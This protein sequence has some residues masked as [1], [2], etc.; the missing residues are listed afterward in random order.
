[1][2]ELIEK[3]E[4]AKADIDFIDT[5]NW[6]VHLKRDEID[7]LLQALQQQENKWISVEDSLPDE[8]E[9]VWI[10]NGKGWTTLGCR[11]CFDNGWH[12]AGTNGVI[13][14]ER[15]KIVSEC[16]SDD[17]DVKFWHSLPTPPNK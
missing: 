10:T 6:W 2:K 14:E 13:Y 8:L 3:L 1:M 17:L 16:E 7:L 5:D 4:N 11:V 9:T 12:W 15:G